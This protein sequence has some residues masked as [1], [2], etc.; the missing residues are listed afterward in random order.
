[1]KNEKQRTLRGVDSVKG[2]GLHTGV[3]VE[4]T[5][6][7]ADENTGFVFVRTD[8]EGDN[9]IPARAEYVVATDRGTSIGNGN[10]TVHTVEHVLAAL[11]GAKVD[12]AIIEVTGEEMPIMDGSAK[13]FTELI[14]NIGTVEQMA[15]RNFIIP[16]KAVKYVCED[17]GSIVELIPDDHFSIDVKID[18]ETE[19]LGEQDAIMSDIEVFN[20]EF[21]SC[22]TFVFLHELEVLLAHNLIK[23]GDL[24]NAIVFVNK[25]ISEKELIRLAKVFDKPE[26]KVLEKGTLN[27]LEL[28]FE[29]EP[30]R[31]KLLDLIGDL[32]L[33]GKPI[34]AKIKAYKPGHKVNWMFTK[35]IL[36]SLA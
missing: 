27:N 15:D 20:D 26:V 31:H 23:G 4:L 2:L 33:L 24:N 36:E 30:A 8:L 12:N 11:V 10:A 1:M 6:K 25:V 14:K 19:V 32:S 21:S 5:F 9:K 28:R 35:K 18:F 22:R 7:P 17:T 29:N 3:E 34:K 13:L 16:K